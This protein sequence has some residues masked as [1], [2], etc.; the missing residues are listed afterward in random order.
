MLLKMALVLFLLGLLL[1]AYAGLVYRH[2]SLD[3]KEVKKEDLVA[4]YLDLIYRLLP[5]PFWFA[6]AGIILM[7]AALIT[8]TVAVCLSFGP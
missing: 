5:G 3:L 4:Y 8:A 2:T 6:A 7:L 1:F